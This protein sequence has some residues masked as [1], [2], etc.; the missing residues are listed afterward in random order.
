MEVAVCKLTTTAR[1]T[2]IDPTDPLTKAWVETWIKAGAKLEAIRR[3]ELRDYVYE[4]HVQEIDDLLN[5]ACRFAQS[6]TTSGLVE[7]QRLFQK[8]RHERDL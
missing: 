8:L 3:Q 6:R 1:R 5:I 7:Q 2:V 4:E